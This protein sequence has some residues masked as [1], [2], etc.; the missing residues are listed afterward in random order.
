M[1]FFR[2]SRYQKNI[3]VQRIALILILLFNRSSIF[4]I[5]FPFLDSRLVKTFFKRSV[6]FASYRSRENGCARH[7]MSVLIEII[8]TT[9]ASIGSVHPQYG[10]GIVSDL[11]PNGSQDFH[12]QRS[13]NEQCTVSDGSSAEHR[14]NQSRSRTRLRTGSSFD[15]SDEGEDGVAT[16][17]IGLRFEATK[18]I[19]RRY[20]T[21]VDVDDARQ[22]ERKRLF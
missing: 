6:L 9:S 16:N 18:S 17:A 10:C 2:F 22:N 12:E 20:R 19:W 15:G 7:E 13:R 4:I 5:D 8:S 3:P 1:F 21:S 11:Q 14:W